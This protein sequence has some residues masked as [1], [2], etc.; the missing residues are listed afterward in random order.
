[1]GVFV[2]FIFLFF[3]WVSLST[4]SLPSMFVCALALWIVTLYL[5]KFHGCNDVRY[6]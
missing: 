5:E 3:I 4:L 2:F 1:M 6:E